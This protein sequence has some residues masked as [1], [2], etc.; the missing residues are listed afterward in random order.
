MPDFTPLS[1]IVMVAYQ[2][3]GGTR[4]DAKGPSTDRKLSWKA[5]IL[6]QHSL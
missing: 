2:L 6:F 5:A 4:V 3:N 1:E